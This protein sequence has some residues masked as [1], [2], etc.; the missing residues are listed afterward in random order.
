M[1]LVAFILASCAIKGVRDDSFTIDA[2]ISID[3]DDL[4]DE[5]YYWDIDPPKDEPE[6]FEYFFED[7]GNPSKDLQP[8]WEEYE[9]GD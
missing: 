6:D 5:I 7:F 4:Y 2:P 9:D 8:T 3:F 1:L